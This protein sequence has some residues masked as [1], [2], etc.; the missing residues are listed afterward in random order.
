MNTKQLLFAHVEEQLDAALLQKRLRDD[1]I[2]A[3]N[4][5]ARSYVLVNVPSQK[6]RHQT[7]YQARP[8]VS[9]RNQERNI[10]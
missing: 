2:Q 1:R 5:S 10:R 8:F 7:S 4:R 9:N 3:N 6:S